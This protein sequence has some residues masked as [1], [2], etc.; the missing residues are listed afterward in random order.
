MSEK[1]IE[2]DGMMVQ[3]AMLSDVV[4]GSLAGDLELDAVLLVENQAEGALPN[5]TRIEKVQL[6]R[7]GTDTFPLG[8]R[9]TIH[10]SLGP[11]TEDMD[12]P[13]MVGEFMYMIFWDQAPEIPIFCT[14]YK[15]SP[16][17][18]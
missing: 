8:A 7:D 16:V 17:K 9:G 6:D 14:G 15:I 10:A 13:E 3:T 5:G 12:L 11:V 4:S 2:I 1:P 18:E